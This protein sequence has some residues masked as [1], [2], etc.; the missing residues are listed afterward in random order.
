MSHAEVFTKLPEYG[1]VKKRKF[2][3]PSLVDRYSKVPLLN[4]LQ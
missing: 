3:S 4:S 1:A 2:N